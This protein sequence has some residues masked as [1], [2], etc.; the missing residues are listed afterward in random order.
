MP[1]VDRNLKSLWDGWYDKGAEGAWGHPNTRPEVRLNYH[2]FVMVDRERNIA[3]DLKRVLGWDAQTR[4]LIVGC[5]FGWVLETLRDELGLASVSGTETSTYIQEYKAV[6]EDADLITKIQGVGLTTSE[7]D[8]LSLFTTFR[9]DGGPRSKRAVDME[10]TE[11]RDAQD[12]RAVR[13]KAGGAGLEILTYDGFMNTLS[14]SEAVDYS[15]RLNKMQAS[16]VIH[17][18][19]DQWLNPRTVEQWKELLPNDTIVAAQGL[20]VL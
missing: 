12:R 18:V 16:R 9:G 4:V 7:G 19:Y 3:I 15:S 6:N 2:R 10:D 5:G 20:V 11:L 8:G 1:Y 13:D 14:D 17:H